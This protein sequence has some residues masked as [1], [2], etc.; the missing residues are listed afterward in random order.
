MSSHEDPKV[1]DGFHQWLNLK[2]GEHGEVSCTR[3]FEHDYLGTKLLICDGKVEVNM[4]DYIREMVR[5]FEDV[6]NN[7][8]TWR[9]LMAKEGFATQESVG[10]NVERREVFHTVVAKGLFEA[11]RA[12]P[13]IITTIFY[14]AT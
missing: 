11:K 2:Y 10:L 13:D 3:G 14:L 8:K 1:N 9:T 6:D 5:C 7:F 12:R 4:I